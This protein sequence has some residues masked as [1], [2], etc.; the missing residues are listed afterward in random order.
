MTQP[1]VAI[2]A[3]GNGD[4]MAIFSNPLMTVFA[5]FPCT[6]GCSCHFSMMPAMK[7]ELVGVLRWGFEC[8]LALIFKI[9][10]GAC[11]RDAP[12]LHEWQ[13]YIAQSR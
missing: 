7:I 5:I 12:G 13:L 10:E 2:A 11:C 9:E 3:V 6:D 4:C 8:E 1:V